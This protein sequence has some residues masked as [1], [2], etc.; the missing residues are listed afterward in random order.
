M[1]RKPRSFNISNVGYYIN[2]PDIEFS[3]SGLSFFCFFVSHSFKKQDSEFL[4]RAVS[5]P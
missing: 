2:M 4:R 3:T 1:T 5:L